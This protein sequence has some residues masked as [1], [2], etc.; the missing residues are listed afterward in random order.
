M[1]YDS[2]IKNQKKLNKFPS[3]INTTYNHSEHFWMYAKW[4]NFHLME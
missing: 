2:T 3:E 4:T 1:H